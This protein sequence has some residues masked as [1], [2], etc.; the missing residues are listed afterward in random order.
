MPRV[1]V[2]CLQWDELKVFMRHKGMPQDLRDQ[3]PT[4]N[5][6]QRRGYERNAVASRNNTVARLLA[7]TEQY[8][9]VPAFVRYRV[10]RG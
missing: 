7:V 1:P 5:F 8:L 2:L 4:A 3:V 6:F 10:T 9:A